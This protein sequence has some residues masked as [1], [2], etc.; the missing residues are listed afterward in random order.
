MCMRFRV[1]LEKADVSWTEA[2]NE[3]D[4]M[5]HYAKQYLN[6]VKDDYRT[7]FFNSPDAKN[8]ANIFAIIELL[9]C[10]S[11]M[12][13]LSVF[14]QLKLIKTNRRICL[15][16]NTLDQ[17]VRINVEGPTPAKWDAAPAIALWWSDKTRRPEPRH[18]TQSKHHPAA[19]GRRPE[20]RLQGCHPSSECEERFFLDEWE[21]WLLDINEDVE[22]PC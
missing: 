22:R 2:K 14:T 15:N 21:E 7:V 6:L 3:W 9:C 12:A 5:V 19:I 17:L 1:L 8:W 11:P 13:T 18:V 20:S 16:E 4:D 10:L